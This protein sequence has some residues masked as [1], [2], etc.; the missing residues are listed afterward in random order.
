[1]PRPL[2]VSIRR[3]MSDCKSL[4]FDESDG[5][6]RWCSWTWVEANTSGTFRSSQTGVSPDPGRRACPSFR[7]R[8]PWCWVALEDWSDVRPEYSF[9]TRT[10]T[11]A[12]HISSTGRIICYHSEGARKAGTERGQGGAQITQYYTVLC[13]ARGD[14][15]KRKDVKFGGRRRCRKGR[16]WCTFCNNND[17]DKVNL[18]GAFS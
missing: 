6:S 7:R 13:L 14:G 3:S 5:D 11:N 12:R 18:Y 9:L 16:R 10:H 15:E 1:M 17:N 4:Q 2:L 8:R